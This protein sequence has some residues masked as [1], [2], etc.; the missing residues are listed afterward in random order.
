MKDF[1]LF[2]KAL[3]LNWVKPRSSLAIHPKVSSY[4]RWRARSFQM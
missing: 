2:E 3:K 1:S 4:Q